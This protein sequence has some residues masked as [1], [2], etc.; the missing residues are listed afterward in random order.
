MKEE[1][2]QMDVCEILVPK[3]EIFVQGIFTLLFRFS[4]S[5]PQFVR[6][7]VNIF[8]AKKARI[9]LVRG[10]ESDRNLAGACVNF[11][12]KIIYFADSSASFRRYFTRKVEQRV[13]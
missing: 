3:L 12:A 7:K 10:Y 13:G 9:F 2:W 5:G 4:H 11:Y 1:I 8:S 6:E